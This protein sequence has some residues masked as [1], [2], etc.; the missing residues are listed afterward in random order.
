MA[1]DED[2]VGL[3]QQAADLLRALGIDFEDNVDTLAGEAFQAL[4]AG[5]VVVAVHF[6][7][8]HELPFFYHAFEFG[9]ADEVVVFA[10]FL[11]AARGA[12][13]VGNGYA[14]VGMMLQQPGDQCGFACA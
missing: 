9:H 3:R 5:A 12:G 2:A 8:F 1:K 14:D 6:G 7:I 13:G 10:V 11:A 4:G